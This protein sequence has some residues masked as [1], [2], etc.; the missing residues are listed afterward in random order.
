VVSRLAVTAIRGFCMGAADIVPG[1]SGG[2]VA[3]V[4]GIYE[5][6][7]GNVGSGAK[8]LGALVRLDRA[9]FRRHLGEIEWLFLL[10]LGAG[11]LTAVA[12]LSSVI[13]RLLRERPEVMAGLVLGLVLGSIVVT[14][15]LRGDR[16]LAHLG[17]LVAVGLVTFVLLGFQS[18]P[19]SDP[20]LVAYFGAGAIAICAMI[21]PGISGSFLLLMMGMYAAVLAAVHD[22]ELLTLAVFAAGA[23]LGLALFSTL[24]NWLLE[25]RHD[26]LLSALIGLMLGSL[27]VLW[28]WPNGVGVIGETRA[29]TISGT[30]LELPASDEILLPVLLAAV[31]FAAVFGV[32]QLA[33]RQV[34]A[35]QLLEV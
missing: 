16:S 2:T 14:W 35:G 25:R 12:L 3:L 22:R 31:A 13:E 5:R 34:P 23:V 8:A 4:F 20:A 30:G 17:L 15:R 29:E 10:P 26:E 7:I 24:L 33:D 32:S 19:V 1:V 28:P 18:G 27:R 21:L 6:L 9:T 11:I